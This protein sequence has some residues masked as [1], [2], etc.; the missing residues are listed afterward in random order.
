[1]SICPAR[2]KLEKKFLFIKYNVSQE[3]YFRF[4]FLTYWGGSWEVTVS[5]PYCNSEKT[6]HCSDED[7]ITM[8]F[9]RIP[10]KRKAGKISYEMYDHDEINEYLVKRMK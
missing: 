6:R 9:K 3:H 7:L 5:C 10:D 2:P 4:V 8:G 1:M